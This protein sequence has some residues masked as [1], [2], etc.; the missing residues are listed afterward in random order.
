IIRLG[1]NTL[2]QIKEPILDELEEFKVFFDRS[3]DSSNHLMQGVIEH[4]KQKNG[5]MMRTIL[6]LLIRKSFGKVE[7]ESIYSAVALELLHTA[8]LIHD[9]IVDESAL[10]RGQPSTNAI[11]D[12]KVSVLAGD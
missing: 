5:K 9:D 3:L 4:I 11:Y 6:I 1:M 2:L 10:R 12:N 8:S 7:D